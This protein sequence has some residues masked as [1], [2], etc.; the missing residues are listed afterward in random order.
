M[1]MYF[2]ILSESPPLNIKQHISLNWFSAPN[3]SL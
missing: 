3:I 2:L 1:N